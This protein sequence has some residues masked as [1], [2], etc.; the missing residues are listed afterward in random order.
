MLV[1][2]ESFNRFP[3]LS[4]HMGG[5]I[6]EVTGAIIDPD[7][8]KVVAFYVDGPEVGR[9]A[10]N[11]LQSKDIREYSSIGMIVDSSDEFINEDDVVALQKIIEIGFFLE[12]KTVETRKGTRLGRVTG[13]TVDSEGFI[14]QQLVVR[15]PLLKSFVDPELLISRSE[16]VKV[17]DDKVV[18]RDEESKIRKKAMT[19]DFVPNFVNPFR[20]PKLSTADTKSLD[21]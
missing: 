10:G 18:V 5:R 21:E 6:A 1:N 8:L 7:K 20:E 19:E 12:G 16:I 3:I 2:S 13:Y 9:E 14:I 15:R 4:V 11:I 17:T